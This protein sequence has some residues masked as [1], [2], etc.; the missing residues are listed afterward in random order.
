MKA[1]LSVSLEHETILKIFEKMRQGNFRNKSH[2][3]E[4]AVLNYLKDEGELKNG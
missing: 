3:V 1:K 4:H 2:L